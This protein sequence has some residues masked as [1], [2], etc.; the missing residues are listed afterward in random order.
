MADET[1][2]EKVTIRDSDGEITDVATLRNGVLEGETLVYSIG[3]L[4][5]RMQFHEGKL[6]G[7]AIYY[8]DAGQ[9]QI[10][11]QYRDGKLHG[12]SLYFGANGELTRKSAFERGLLHGY[13]VDYYL[14]G[15]PREVTSYKNNIKEGEW[16]RLNEDGKVL[17]R[18]YYHLG[19][20]QAP[21]SAHGKPAAK[22][23]PRK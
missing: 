13:T 4:A 7:P 22:T 18:L 21:E 9:V 23:A 16:L 2:I 3:R 8:D 12:D 17:E 19:K 6:N 14:S 10:K 1:G 5:A 20:P 11:A 15:K